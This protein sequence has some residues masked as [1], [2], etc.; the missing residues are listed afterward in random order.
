LKRNLPR[1][2]FIGA[3]T[4]ATALACGLHNK[5]YAVVAVASLHLASAQKLSKFVP[6]CQPC[7]EKQQ[8]VD[9]ADII[10]ITTP[11]DVIAQVAGEVKWQ[12]GKS[13]LHCS[14]ADTS[15]LLAK[16]AAEGASVGVI[17]PLQTFAGAEQAKDSLSGITFSIEAQE[18]LAATLKSMAKSLGGRAIVLKPEDRVLYHASAV[19][20]SNYLV[21]LMKMSTDLWAG[22]GLSREE[23][24]RALAP[25]IKGTVNNIETIGLP[26]C[27]SGPISRGDTGTLK[28]HLA[29]LGD[30]HDG[31]T[32]AYKELGLQTI[33]V[34]LAKGHI[35]AARASEMT[36]VLKTAHG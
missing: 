4:V 27:L 8:V 12:A 24:V 17:H 21:T 20:V 26:D 25:L 1:I 19:M 5:G 9:A 6:N 23:A 2:G 22:F 29:A 35:D 28:K 16:A 31:I 18:P 36:T 7:P 15:A 34:A 3:G 13:A 11:D 32:S 33:P 10:F 14:G 30:N